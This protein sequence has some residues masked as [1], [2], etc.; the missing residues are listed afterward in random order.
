MPP[1][2]RPQRGECVYFRSD[3]QEHIS[4]TYSAGTTSKSFARKRIS[5]AIPSLEDET[6]DEHG[7]NTTFRG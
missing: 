4:L 3:E 1:S 2:R 6:E 5:V 7:V